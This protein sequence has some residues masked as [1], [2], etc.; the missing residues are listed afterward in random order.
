MR[1]I[2]GPNLPTFTS[3]EKNLLKAKLDFI[4][5]NQY[6]TTYAKDCIYSSCPIDLYNG[7]ALVSTTGERNGQFIGTPVRMRYFPSSNFRTY[8]K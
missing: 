8:K 2:L 3:E 5:I 1:Q 6:T 7:N 4:G